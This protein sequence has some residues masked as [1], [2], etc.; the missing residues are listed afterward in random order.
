MSTPVHILSIGVIELLLLV[1]QWLVLA[2]VHRLPSL[3]VV[4]HLAVLL[5]VA[6]QLVRVDHRQHLREALAH[7]SNPLSRVAERKLVP[8]HELDAFTVHVDQAFLAR[9]ARHSTERLFTEHGILFVIS[10]TI[11]LL[12]EEEQV[13][14]LL[15]MHLEGLAGVALVSELLGKSLHDVGKAILESFVHLSEVSLLIKIVLE[16]LDP[17]C[18]LV[19]QVSKHHLQVIHAL[20]ESIESF[21]AHTTT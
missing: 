6:R 19:S 8:R 1:V 2:H 17:L 9:S 11:E 7:A 5:L 4:I 10:L 16:L 18:E 20:N 15:L 3:T 21:L 12:H 13:F 14:D